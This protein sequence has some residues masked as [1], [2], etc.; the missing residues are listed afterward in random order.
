MLRG[1]VRKGGS[2]REALGTFDRQEAVSKLRYELHKLEVEFAER[3]RELK[4]VED[5]KDSRRGVEELS[6]QEGNALVTRWFIEMEKRNQGW[7]DQDGSRLDEEDLPDI[8]D[9]LHVDEAAY[10]GG[11]ASIP[12]ADCDDTLA[13]LLHEQ[14]IAS[15]KEVGPARYRRQG[16]RDR[17]I[18]VLNAN[19]CK[20]SPAFRRLSG[21]LQ[22]AVLESLRRSMD[23]IQR[24]ALRSHDTI[25]RDVFAHST[26]PKWRASVTLD[27][28]IKRHKRQLV[29]T[30][31]TTGTARTY[32]IP[33]RLLK[34]TFGGRS[35]LE[36][37]TKEKVEELF[38]WMSRIPVNC[39]QR[40]P[41]M[42]FAQAVKAAD[43]RGD[44]RRLGGSTLDN[45]FNNISAIF[46]FGV[47]KELMRSNPASD[48]Y[49]RAMVRVEDT[50]G[51]KAQFSADELNRMFR[52]P[53]YTGCKD[54]LDGYHKAGNFKGRRGRFWVP[55]IA[56]FGGFRCNEIVQLYTED[57]G[58]ADGIP[59]FFV[60]EERANGAKCDKILKTKQSRRRVPIHP[61]LIRLGFLKFVEER[62]LDSQNPRLFPELEIGRN[63]Y[64]SDPFSKWFGRF[65]K[66]SIGKECKATFHSFRHMFRDALRNGGVRDSDAERLG[67]WQTNVSRSAE[68]GYGEGPHLQYLHREISKVHYPGLNL[69]HLDDV[70]CN[71]QQKMPR[72]RM[73]KRRMH[74]LR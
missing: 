17:G 20:P 45:Y 14:G 13:I 37:I 44:A 40:Y 50:S 49:L 63:G 12:A 59:F 42:S 16:P 41:G 28:L 52:A 1:K 15:E 26:P 11:T 34:E 27:E 47:V 30:S 46:N 43:R 5:N 10:Q 62:R 65:K 71:R 51:P 66:L 64:Y 22:R 61:E 68:A 35:R 7:W 38:R 8:L 19:E 67:G 25:F 69:S 39:G 21:L 6:E 31:R 48:K 55:L 57:V 2:I 33:Y 54:D 72:Q 32:A 53:L 18:A 58:E 74:R 36:T 4:I 56:L 73:K 24:K 9:D 70:F 23:R 29:D 60:R 3:R